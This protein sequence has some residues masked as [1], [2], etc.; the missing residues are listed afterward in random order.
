MSKLKQIVKIAARE[1]AIMRRHSI[2]GFCMVVFP[3]L[4]VIFFT[5]IMREG[6]PEDMPVGVVDDDNTPATRA[7][8]RRLDAMQSS[9]VEGRYATV[10]D[11]REAIQRNHIYAFLYIPKGTTAGLARGTRP[12]MSL[13]YSGVTMVAG[14]LLFKDMKTV[15]ALA[16]AQVGA[17]KLAAIGKSGE[18]IKATLQ[19]VAI[20]LH[21]IGNPWLSYNIY[22]STTMVPGLL[23]LFIFLITPYSIGTELKFNRSKEWLAM[24]GGDI[25]VAMAGKLLP[26]AAIFLT[27]FYAYEFYI[28]HVLGFPHPGGVAPILL[29]GLLAVAA[30]EGAGVFAF[31]LWPSLR[32][33]MSM[34]SLW[35]VLSFSMC[36]A[37][38]PVFA[39]DPMIE[40]MAALFPLRHYYMVYQMTIFN[41][42][43]LA[44]AWRDIAALGVFALLPAL[45]LWNVRKAMLKYVYIP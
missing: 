2:Y 39:M 5:S 6:V 24:A 37:T 15:V 13:Y 16:S 26:Q 8:V 29:L 34:C 40:A 7:M 12:K 42:F 41:G 32:M 14:S 17:G 45:T 10:D 38:F 30:C 44:A 33:S 43:P 9:H 18:E 27:I 1:C 28:F 25:R 23:M 19:P 22:L 35:S 11:A 36:G 31:G 20:D 21:L 4:V 3:V